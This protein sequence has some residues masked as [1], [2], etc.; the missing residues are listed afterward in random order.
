LVT[1]L[2]IL[3]VWALT[4]GEIRSRESVRYAPPRWKLLQLALW[5]DKSLSQNVLEPQS[6]FPSASVGDSTLSIFRSRPSPISAPGATYRY[7]P[8]T[9]E[10][11]ANFSLEDSPPWLTIDPES[12]VVTGTPRDVDKYE[13]TLEGTMQD[14]RR[15]RQSFSIFVD[16]RLLPLGTDKRG[17]DVARVLVRASRYTLVPGLIAVLIGVGLGVIV[18]ALGAFYG[19]A[20]LRLVRGTSLLLQS[21]PGLLLVFLASAISGFNLL[22]SMAVVGLIL[23]P[24]TAN[25]IMERVD[26]LK[27]S[28]FVEAAREL[29]LTDREILW[30][31]IVWHN[32]RTFVA[33][34]IMQ[35]FA[36]AIL[37]E[38]T[39]S[40]MGLANPNSESLGKMLRDGREALSGRVSMLEAPVALIALLAVV[41]ALSMLERGVL[42]LWARRA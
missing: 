29:G 40:Y 24:E 11:L 2:A 22:V 8:R 14:G 9:S 41:F 16:D 10:P 31:E 27:R 18:G 39:L 23:L 5:N 17:R 1:A 4:M 35:G 19:G 12:G 32:A 28:D 21:V 25:G 30:T 3:N 26:S 38:V 20:A 34:R 15:A 36:F 33:S 42:R 7:Q 13:V 37:V 6:P